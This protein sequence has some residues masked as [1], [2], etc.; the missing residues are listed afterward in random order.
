MQRTF[1][2]TLVRLSGVALLAL[3]LGLPAVGV[4]QEDVTASTQTEPDG[5]DMM[6]D[7]M[8][9]RPV[10][11]VRTVF[12]TV[13]WVAALPFTIFSGSLVDAGDNLVVEPAAHTFTRPLGVPRPV[14]R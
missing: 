10:G 7:F 2:T 12:G 5:R 8:L 3:A 11:L 6:G 1:K 9:Q 13:V 4:A 14:D